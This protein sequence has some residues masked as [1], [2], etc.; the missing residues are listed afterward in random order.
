[1]ATSSPIT[2]SSTAASAIS[3]GSL[4]GEAAIKLRQVSSD[5]TNDLALLQAP[6]PFKEMATIRGSG[7]PLR[8]RRGRDRLSLP[9]PAVLGF[10]GH[11]GDRQFAGGSTTTPA[12]CRS[13]PRSSR[14]TAAAHCWTQ[15][16]RWSAWWSANSIGVRVVQ[17]DRHHSRKHQFRHQDRRA[18]RL[19]RQQRGAYQTTDAKPASGTGELAT[20]EIAK[21]ARGFTLLISCT[22]NEQS[23]SAKK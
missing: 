1:M 4:S 22:A 3:P 11:H 12:T 18:A 10:Y 19:P 7:A 21:N 2:M 13:A 9:R 20:P 8:R 16:V 23:A 6:G 5:E 17:G 15:V 14:A